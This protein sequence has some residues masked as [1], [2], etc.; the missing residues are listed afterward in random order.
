V[1]IDGKPISQVPEDLGT[2]LL[3]L[4]MTGKIFSEI[5]VFRGKKSVSLYT[6]AKLAGS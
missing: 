5:Q 2:I 3:E 1:I 6:H 4:E